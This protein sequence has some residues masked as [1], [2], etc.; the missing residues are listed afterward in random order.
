LSSVANYFHTL[1]YLRSGQILGRARF[2]LFRP[3]TDERPA[4]GLRLPRQ[5]YAAPIRAAQS[6]L[7]PDRFRLLNFEADC[8]G[9]ADWQG[10]AK[11]Q[12][13]LYNL[14][15]FDDLN[16]QG[17][18]SRTSWH[19][20]LI[21]RWI[22]ENPPARGIGW[23][24]YPA[25]RR[26]VNW[27]KWSMAGNSPTPKMRQSLAVQTRWLSRRI[28]SHLQGNHVFANAKALV[29]AGM[30]FEGGEAQ[31]WQ[32]RGL[33]LM[34][35]EIGEQ[36]LADGG[37]SERSTTY[38][39]GF[40]ED[41]LDTIG[42]MQAYGAAVDDAWRGTVSRMMDWL[43][44][45]S[46]PDGGIAFF[47]DAAFG[48]SPEPAQ[49][50]AYAGRLGVRLNAAKP[51][52]TAGMRRLPASGYVSIDLPPFFLVCDVAPIG[53]DHLPAHA[54]ADTL[55]FEMSFEGR[56]VFVNSGTSEYGSGAERQ[57]QRGTAAHNTLVLDGENS[58]EVWA[59][60]RVAR[61]SRARLLAAS[62]DS[63]TAKVEGEHDG[64]RRLRGRNIHRRSWSLDERELVIEDAVE[65]GF[66]DA[67]CYFH[68]HP[69]IRVRRSGE[70]TLEL[71]DSRG[72]LLD[73]GFE[74]AAAVDVV[75]ST[76]HPEFGAALKNQC[77][78]ARLEG[79]RMATRI[80]RSGST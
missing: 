48:V 34:R 4:P 19:R 61:R 58:S 63:A 57:R 76:W 46:H 49:L 35:A 59:A 10:G 23:D 32:R 55:S 62:S 70:S 54:H 8:A 2:K 64:Y 36:V 5:A 13:W 6:M 53:P 11:A 21:D 50:R 51:P 73:V 22:D 9:E 79:A 67:R 26:I 39:A 68:V 71:A 7:A 20:D 3:R 33:Q 60:F 1:R 78:V 45:M 72:A 77:I 52:G 56:R 18:S 44:A 15:Y 24:P 74:G 80:R 27:I 30:F 28:E 65:G 40:V 47:N 17:A 69:E 41:L 29:H 25:S 14:H 38:H 31:R 37:H 75:D 12:L 42:I 43:E 16:A 66:S